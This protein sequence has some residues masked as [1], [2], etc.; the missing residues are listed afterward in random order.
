MKKLIVLFLVVITA[1]VHAQSD[2]DLQGHR[3]CRGLMP[4]NSIPAFIKAIEMGVKT[5]EMDVVITRDN[6]VVVSHEPWMSEVICLQPDGAPVPSNSMQQFNIYQMSHDS[7]KMFDCGSRFHPRFTQQLR[8]P[9]YKPLLSEVIDSV[10]A[11]IRMNNLPAVSYNIETKCQ[12]LG[13]RVFHPEPATFVDL[14]YDVLKEKDVLP[15]VSIQS[16]DVR[17]LQVLRKKDSTIPLVLLVENPQGLDANLDK[18]GFLPQVYSPF[19]LLVTP[20]LVKAVHERGM[21]II[22]WTVNDQRDI[23]IILDMG[24]DGMITDYPDIAKS[25]LEWR[26]KH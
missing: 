3:G 11:Y 4:E 23:G 22:P 13:D 9:V 2:F 5:L 12:P 14:V 19:Y 10:E 18:L 15:K 20:E 25:L 24:V 7:V 1:H 21:K 17:T 16:F 6:K 8:Q 26:V